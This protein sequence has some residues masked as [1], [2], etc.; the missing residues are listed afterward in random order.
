[1]SGTFF[2]LIC[3]VIERKIGKMDDHV[4]LLHNGQMSIG[5][6]FIKRVSTNGVYN[7]HPFQIATNVKIRHLHFH[8]LTNSTA[9]IF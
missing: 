3:M 8:P 9:S 1:M 2:D 6:L 7:M 5:Q 4:Y